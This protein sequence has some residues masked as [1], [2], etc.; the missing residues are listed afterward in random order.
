MPRNESDEAAVLAAPYAGSPAKRRQTSERVVICLN[1]LYNAIK[2][3]P[4][5]GVISLKLGR[6]GSGG[7]C[8]GSGILVEEIPIVLASFGQGSIKSAQ[9][10]CGLGLPV[11]KNLIDLHRGTFWLRSKLRK[12]VM[13]RLAECG[14]RAADPGGHGAIAR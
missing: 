11:A 6:S 5:G 1:L 12:S 2:F 9:R 8:T 7:Q 4:K 3:T 14:R 13:S 10:D